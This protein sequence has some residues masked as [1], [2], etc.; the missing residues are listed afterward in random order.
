MLV[1]QEVQETR[2]QQPPHKEMLVELVIPDP[3]QIMEPAVAE[4]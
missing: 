4:V 1:K 3:M 2:L